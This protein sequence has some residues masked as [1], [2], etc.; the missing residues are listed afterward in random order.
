M[1]KLTQA[2]NV[3]GRGGEYLAGL[4]VQFFFSLIILSHLTEKS[5][6]QQY[7]AGPGCSEAG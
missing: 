7:V 4:D 3:S 6:F 2:G 1:Y 5:K